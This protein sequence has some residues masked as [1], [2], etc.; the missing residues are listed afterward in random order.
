MQCYIIPLISITN[1]NLG[2][3]FSI[4][5]FGPTTQVHR[6]APEPSTEMEKKK[7]D[8]RGRRH[9]QRWECAQTREVNRPLWLVLT[10]VTAHRHPQG[11]RP[12]WQVNRAHPL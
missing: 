2:C 6:I 11:R 5:S 10:R 4:R 3:V 12:D 7:K 8:F 9:S 1:V